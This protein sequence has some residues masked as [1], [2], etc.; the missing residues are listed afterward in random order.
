M[1]KKVKVVI[2]F[3]FGINILRGKVVYIFSIRFLILLKCS[4]LS[5]FRFWVILFFGFC[6]F[7]ILCWE[8]RVEGRIDVSSMILL[9]NRGI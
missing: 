7:R 3:C 6:N 8:M 5:F 9:G 1:V 4:V 2:S